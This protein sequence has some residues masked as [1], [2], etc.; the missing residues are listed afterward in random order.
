MNEL[1]ESGTLAEL[2]TQGG[3]AAARSNGHDL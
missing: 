2:L 3:A 1:R